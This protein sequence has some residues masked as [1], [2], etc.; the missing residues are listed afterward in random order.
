IT[1]AIKS[2]AQQKTAKLP[3]YYS[4]INKI[5]VLIDGGGKNSSVEIIASAEHSKLFIA[6]ETGEDTYACIDA[7]TH[8][9]ERQLARRKGRERDNKH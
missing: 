2:Y 8:K 1:E 6:T 3:R 9:L 4:S 5:E 7:A